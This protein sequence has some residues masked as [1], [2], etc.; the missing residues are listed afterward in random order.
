MEHSLYFRHGAKCFMW[1]ASFH[2]LR[3]LLQRD[4]YFPDFIGGE[5]NLRLSEV[6]DAVNKWQSQGTDPDLCF[7]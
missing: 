1:T 6:M 4:Y 7:R 5:S 3:I 2:N